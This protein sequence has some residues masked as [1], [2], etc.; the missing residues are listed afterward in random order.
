MIQEII[1][2][3]PE[4]SFLKVDGHDDAI[5]GVDEATMRLCYSVGKIIQKLMSHG[6]THEEAIEYFEFNISGA[7]MGEKNPIYVYDCFE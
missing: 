3:Y 4:E 2:Y 5:I 1:E 7:Y 6:M